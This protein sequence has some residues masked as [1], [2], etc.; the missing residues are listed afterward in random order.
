MVPVPGVK[1][2]APYSNS[3]WVSNPLGVQEKLAEIKSEEVT[4]RF[5]GEGHEGASTIDTSSKSKSFQK[6][7]I[8]AY[9]KPVIEKKKI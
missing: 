8:Y 1:P 4:A 3:H 5:E 6:I 2:G 9:C 7:Y